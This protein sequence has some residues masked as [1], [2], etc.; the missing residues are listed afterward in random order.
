MAGMMIGKITARAEWAA[1]EPEDEK[2]RSQDAWLHDGDDV[3][4]EEVGGHAGTV[5]DVVP[6]IVRRW[7]RVRGG[8]P[9]DAGLDL[10]HQSAPSRPPW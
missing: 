2:A 10:A 8:R 4:L 6:H 3:G 1:S 5:A 7:W 9:R